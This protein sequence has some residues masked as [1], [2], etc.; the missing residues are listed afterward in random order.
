MAFEIDSNNIEYYIVKLSD[1][2]K[3]RK[4]HFGGIIFNMVT[5][6]VIEVD[7]EAFTVVSAI[8]EIEIVV[9]KVLL[10]MLFTNKNRKFNKKGAI[11]FLLRLI[12]MGI[13]DVL[14]NGILSES[15]RKM[16]YGKISNKISWPA[17]EYLSAPETVHWAVTYRC[18][19]FCPDCYIERYKRMFTYELNTNEAFKLID[20][21]ADSGVFQ[22]AIGGGE[23]FKRDDLEDIVRRASENGLVTHITT[24]RYEIES[25]CLDLLAKYI[26]TFQVGIRT[27][28]LLNTKAEE[29]LGKLV[30]QLAEHGIIPGANLIMTRNSIQNIEKLVERLSNI[31]FKRLTLLRYKPPAN[32]GRWLKEKPYK[33][34]LK[35]LEEKLTTI[36][37]KHTDI[38]FRIDCALTFI[39]R[40]L[41]PQIALNSGIRGC[42]AAQRMLFIAPDGSVYPC[43]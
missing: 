16:L 29:C 43:S 30:M 18:D 28:E 20:K 37:E 38:I 35:L 23:P 17:Y 26:K 13:I 6:D 21:I 33:Y 4:E 2:I 15:Y 34:E 7:R 22:L 27:E 1:K 9:I 32:I 3:I 19:E 36:Q 12:D 24:G 25:V 40:I 11:N 5:G 10:E 14:P 39:Q 41:N 8:K 42:A 31:G